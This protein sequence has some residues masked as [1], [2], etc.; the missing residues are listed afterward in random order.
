MTSKLLTPEDVHAVGVAAVENALELMTDAAVLLGAGRPLRAY[1]LGVIAVEEVAKHLVC[2]DKLGHWE[3]TLTVSELNE[4]LRPSAAH[5]RRYGTALA[6]LTGMTP[7]VPLPEGFDDINALA[8][9]DMQSRERALYV[10]VAPDGAPMTPSDL[11]GESART[12]V[13]A[14]IGYFTMLGSAWRAGLDDD[15]AIAR[16]EPEPFAPP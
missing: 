5:A 7:S 9:A 1:A 2:R 10:E 8:R 4:A 6:Y 13:S 16:G 3:A 11:S 12:W 15:L 14:M